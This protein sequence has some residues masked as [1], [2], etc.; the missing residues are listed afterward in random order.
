MPAAWGLGLRGGWSSMAPV[1]FVCVYIHLFIA[2]VLVLM[3]L[4][5]TIT[6]YK[7]RIILNNSSINT[8]TLAMNKCIYTQ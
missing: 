3:L 2:R 7:H 4:L 8:K 1:I 5:F 6:E